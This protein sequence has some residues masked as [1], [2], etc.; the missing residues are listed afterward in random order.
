MIVDDG[1]G[2]RDGAGRDAGGGE[3]G[4]G[5]G[6][7]HLA[8]GRGV[9]VGEDAVLRALACGGDGD[10]L[11]GEDG[12]GVGGAGDGRRLEALNAEACGALC[13]LAGAVVEAAGDGVVSGGEAGGGQR[14]CLGGAGDLSAGGRPDV[15]RGLFAAEVGRSGGD[16]DGVAGEGVG[17][18]GDAAELDGGGGLVV[19][20]RRVRPASRR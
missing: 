19:P 13:L 7:V 17:G 1:A 18:L 11:A 16:G 5:A 20:R 8:G 12:C 9:A 10:G 14:C 4:V 3:R 15:G 2:D 6:A